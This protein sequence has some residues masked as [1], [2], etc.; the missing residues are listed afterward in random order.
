MAEIEINIM[1][2]ECLD[3][4]IGNKQNIE[5]E[6]KIWCNQNNKDKRKINWS[7]TKN[8]A[9]KKLSKYYAS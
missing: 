9:D 3:R 4:N 5:K 7:F 6:L 1:D 8:Q 2:K